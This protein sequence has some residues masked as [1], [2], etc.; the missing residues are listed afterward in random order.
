MLDLVRTFGWLTALLGVTAVSGVARAEVHPPRAIGDTSVARPDGA[1]GAAEVVLELVVA[2]DGTV[3]DVTVVSGAEPF[4]SAAV[5]AARGFTFTP[6]ERDGKAVPARIRLIVEFPQP[7]TPEAEPAAP[8]STAAPDTAPPATA[9]PSAPSSAPP[10][11]E[12]PLEVSVEGRKHL[13]A[14]GFTRAEVR[15]MPGALGDPLRAIEPLP[16]VTPTLSG[17]PYFFVRGAPPSDVGYFYDGIRLPALFHALGGPSVVHPSLVA[18]VE[19]YPGPYP[20]EYGRFAAAAVIAEAAP[21][22]LEPHGEVNVR[23]TDSSALVDTPLGDSVNV[24]AG[25]RYAYANPILHLFAPDTDVAY[26][27]YQ[28]RVR[29]EAWRDG[30]VTLLIFGAHDLLTERTDDGRNTL[31]GVDFHRAAVRAEHDIERGKLRFQLLGGWDRSFLHN[32]DVEVDD[33]SLELRADIERAAGHGAVWRAGV[34]GGLDR[35]TLELTGLDDADAE[36]RYRD[37]FPARTDFTAGAY[38]ACDLK[39]GSRLHVTPGVRADV[40]VVSGAQAVG[41]D[42]RVS[43]AYEASKS[44][45]LHSGIGIAHQPPAESLPS[46]GLSPRLGDGLQTGVAHNFGI[47]LRLPAGLGIDVTAFQTAIFGLRDAA[48]QARL[49]DADPSVTEDTRGIGYARGVEVLLK[50][51]LTRRLGGFIAY[52]LASARRSVGRSEVPSA[53]DRRHVVSAALSQDWGRGFHSGMRGTFYTGI[54]ADV[55]YVEA[56]QS[57]PRT[58]SFYRLDLRGE[59]RF[60][61]GEKGSLSIVLEVL[62]ATMNKEVLNESCNA[63]VCKEHRVGPVTIPNLGLEAAF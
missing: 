59:K 46:P 52:T 42:P 35:Y 7:V 53:F 13:G 5:G 61:W 9:A 38:V 49:R 63:Y 8:P 2:K 34:N 43:F 33:R 55:A 14:R 23:A 62:N 39:L 40:Y 17:L 51:S 11:P 30:R 28:L 1:V 6:A 26:W 36:R 10:A 50:R 56:A 24:A 16:G 3:S 47:G 32:G 12:E 15:E 37:Q 57:P 29:A 60:R 25:G 19:L 18:G 58:R 21:P 45:T 22:S 27:D 20:V 41:V 44:V 48:G 54:P 31:Y 4:A